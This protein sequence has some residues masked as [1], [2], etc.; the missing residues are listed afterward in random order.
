MRTVKLVTM[1]K[2]A[3]KTCSKAKKEVN[4]LRSCKKRLEE[5]LFDA[6]HRLNDLEFKN[7]N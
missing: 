2:P 5:Y 4:R 1:L 7:K 6:E 3:P